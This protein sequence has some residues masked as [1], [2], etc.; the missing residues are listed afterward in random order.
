MNQPRPE[1]RDVDVAQPVGLRQPEAG[2]V[3]PA[4]VVEI[5]L[6]ILRDHRVGVDRCAEIEARGRLAAD[7][8]GLCRQGQMLQQAFLGSDS[9]HAFGHADAQ[10][11][12]TVHR[13]FEGA[14]SGDHLARVK[15]HWR[16][17]SGRG[18]HPVGE[19]LRKP[20]G[21]GLHM[22]FRL[23]HHHGIHQNAGDLHLARGQG[24]G[25]GHPFDLNDHHAAGVLHRHRLRQVV[26][27]QRLALHGDI[28]GL[29]GGGAPQQRHRQPLR[30]IKQQLLSADLHQVQ[31]RVG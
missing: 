9:G 22:M 30:P 20:G 11:D 13:Q 17:V 31:L 4:A 1:A 7:H 10:I 29:V 15:P 14:A 23:R 12:H 2:H 28:A 16:H 26:D 21:I 5:E 24:A 8:P 6:R 18:A 25:A 3:E 19:P 27:G